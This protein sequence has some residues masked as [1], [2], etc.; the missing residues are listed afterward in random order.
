M[1][2][3][4]KPKKITTTTKFYILQIEFDTINKD[5]NYKEKIFFLFFQRF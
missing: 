2:V 5:L 4:L 1:E 3:N